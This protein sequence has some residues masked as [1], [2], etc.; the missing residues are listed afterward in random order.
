MRK[1]LVT[2]FVTLDG[3][4]QAP[5]GPEEDPS[6]GFAHGGWSVAYWDAAMGDWMAGIMQPP[7]DLLLGRRT[8]EIFAGFWPAS[9]DP[10][11]NEL[12]EATKHVASRTLQQVDWQNSRL[13]EGDAADAVRAL[14][15]TEG[16]E[17]QVHGSGNLIQTLLEQDL[18]DE[19]HLWVF[20]VVLGSGKRLFG[21]GTTPAGLEL[22]DS[23]VSSTGVVLLTYRRAGDPK[24]GSFA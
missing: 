21:S 20:P 14:K 12:N 5:G 4:M 7:F 15:E 22:V 9:T 16:P 13:L 11:A 23:K 3:V 6:D 18:I 8:Y 24:Y 1:L 10:G 2:T 19:F 17:L